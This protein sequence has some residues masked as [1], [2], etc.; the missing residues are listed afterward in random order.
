MARSPINRRQRPTFTNRLFYADSQE[1]YQCPPLRR[2]A[3]LCEAWPS[4]PEHVI[5]VILAL[6]DPS[7]VVEATGI[8]SP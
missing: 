5:L 1:N 2:P 6:A 4:L 3:R 8:K 7:R